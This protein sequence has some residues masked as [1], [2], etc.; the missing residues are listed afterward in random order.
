[1]SDWY[2]QKTWSKS[3]EEYFFQKLGRARKD[4]RAQYLK[5][6]AIELI[7]Q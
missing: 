5:V 3:Q 1:M 2:R 4:G 6:Q 7:D